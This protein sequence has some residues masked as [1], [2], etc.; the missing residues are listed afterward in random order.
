MYAINYVFMRSE[1]VIAPYIYKENSNKD[2]Y[3]YNKIQQ[4]NLF[5][6][7]FCLSSFSNPIK[8]NFM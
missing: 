6:I 7:L 8:F 1:S 2:V 5:K 4:S 3:F